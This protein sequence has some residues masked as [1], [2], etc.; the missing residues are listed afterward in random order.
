MI[1][2]KH[3]YS[4]EFL[5]TLLNQGFTNFH[6]DGSRLN[7]K[8]YN[9]IVSH[10]IDYA[11]TK[12]NTRPTIIFDLKS[13]L[14]LITKISENRKFLKIYKGQTIKISYET[15]REYEG[16]VIYIDKK[17][18]QGVNIGDILLISYP[19]LRLKVVGVENSL[20]SSASYANLRKKD[21]YSQFNQVNCIKQIKSSPSLFKDKNTYNLYQKQIESYEE[22]YK[23]PEKDANDDSGNF[24]NNLYD[25]E[26]NINIKKENN[27]SNN[28]N[29]IMNKYYPQNVIEEDEEYLID[30]NNFD[31]FYEETLKH[32]HD[33][34]EQSYQKIMIRYNAMDKELLYKDNDKFSTSMDKISAISQIDMLGKE[35]HYENKTNL[36]L[37]FIN[38]FRQSI[39]PFQLSITRK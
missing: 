9:K 2:L 31:N 36:F 33:K 11:E 35:I 15:K 24:P 28:K 37:L 8:I 4:K 20:M 30:P 12:L 39:S 6:I 38:S 7:L 21:N 25:D 19:E 1:S 22:S 13:P 10:L 18:S 5:E 3:H 16:D 27:I 17:I 14:P 23:I 32:K 34:L 29:S 26:I